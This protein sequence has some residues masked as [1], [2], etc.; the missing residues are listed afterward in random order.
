M[1]TY[2]QLDPKNELQLNLHEELVKLNNSDF[3]QTGCLHQQIIFI[4]WSV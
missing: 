4:T 1:P 3:A 2:G